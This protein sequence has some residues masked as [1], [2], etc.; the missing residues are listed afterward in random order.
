M[1]A[2]S[3]SG[4]SSS[5]TGTARCRT[6]GPASS[7][8]VDEVHGHA[9]HLDAVLERLTLRVEAGKRRQQ[10]RMDVQ[11]ACGKASSIGAPKQA[12]EPGEADEADVARAQ[13]AHER[14]IVVVAGRP[15]SMTQMHSV[16][17]PGVAGPLEPG[18]ILHVRDD[19]GDRRARAGPRRMASMSACRLL[20]RPEMSTPK[21][22]RV[23]DS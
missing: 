14:A 8:V 15:A 10:R 2:A 21:R 20:P 1:R 3:V 23:P 22:R 6:I 7:S 4:V 13:L 18:G 9:A 17:I 19:D 12:H 5:S 16:S 11:D